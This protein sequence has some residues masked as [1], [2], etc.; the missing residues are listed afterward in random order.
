MW[1]NPPLSASGQDKANLAFSS[2]QARGFPCWSRK[3][4]FS[5][6][7]Y[8][9]SFIN[10]ACSVNIA[11][12]LSSFFFAF[13]LFF[14]LHFIDRNERIYKHTLLLKETR[15]LT[16]IFKLYFDRKV[17]TH[18]LSL[19]KKVHYV[20]CL[21]SRKMIKFNPGLR[22]LLSKVCLSKFMCLKLSLFQMRGRKSD[23]GKPLVSPSIS[24]VF[25]L[26]L[27]RKISLAPRATIFW[28]FLVFPGAG[29]SRK[30]RKLKTGSESFFLYI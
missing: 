16:G 18:V 10:Q 14:T 8:D 2:G 6:L 30:S 12:Q 29:F 25:I 24:L 4:K 21:V 17:V 23:E 7:A 1:L 13:F 15:R 11:G 20:N 5:F 27:P 19:G 26:H 28:T 9:K 3:K 22:Q